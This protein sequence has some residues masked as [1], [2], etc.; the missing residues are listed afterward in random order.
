MGSGSES[1]SGTQKLELSNAVVALASK[2]SDVWTRNRL[3]TNYDEARRQ[4]LSDENIWHYIE[5]NERSIEDFDEI[6][7]DL[8]LYLHGVQISSIVEPMTRVLNI[9]SSTAGVRVLSPVLREVNCRDSVEAVILAA[10]QL[11]VDPP[12]GKV[13]LKRAM[14]DYNGTHLFRVLLASHLLWRVFWHHYKTRGSVHFLSSATRILAPIGLVP[15]TKKIE[16]AKKGA[17]PSAG[18]ASND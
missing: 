2:F 3:R 6:K 5:E 17:N 10:W 16:Q 9:V 18:D 12:I 8:D 11:E 7:K 1:L 14:G 15:P 13:S 4:L